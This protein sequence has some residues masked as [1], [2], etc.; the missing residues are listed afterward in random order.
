MH[1]WRMNQNIGYQQYVWMEDEEEM[2]RFRGVH[3]S[4][5]FGFYQKK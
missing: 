3:G 1:M 4:V 2:V 5:R